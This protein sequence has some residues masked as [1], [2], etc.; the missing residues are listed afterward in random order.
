[1]REEE[2]TRD[3]ASGQTRR[4]FVKLSGVAGVSAILAGV[5]NESAVAKPQPPTVGGPDPKICGSTNLNSDS[6]WRRSQI[7]HSNNSCLQ[8]SSDYV[9]M[10]G[11]D[12]VSNYTNYILVPTQRINGIE[13]PWICNTSSP[14]YWSAAEFYSHQPPTRVPVPVGLGINSEHARKLNQLHIH[15]ATARPES[16]ADLRSHDGSAARNLSAW[17]ATRVS[18]RG[19]SQSLGILPHTYRV[20]VWAGFSHD[21]LFDMLRTM[22]VHAL[23]A[24]ATV[25][26]AQAKMRFQTL[27]VIPRTIGNGGFYIVNSESDLRDPNNTQLT[28]SDTCDPLLLLHP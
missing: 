17:A 24:G 2:M 20:L 5:G 25:A 15:M 9:V 21:N 22:L 7:C 12:N 6:L 1:M 18:I 23:G 27:I 8:N 26:D 19:F 10:A 28:G 4:R 13:C 14:N 3:E 16:M 11:N